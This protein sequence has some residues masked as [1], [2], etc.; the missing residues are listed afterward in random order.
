MPTNQVFDFSI[1]MATLFNFGFTTTRCT[2]ETGDSIHNESSNSD[3][4][5]EDEV[6]ENPFDPQPAINQWSSIVQ[7]R[8]GSRN[9]HRGQEKDQLRDSVSDSDSFDFESQYSNS[10]NESELTEDKL[11]IK[12]FLMKNNEQYAQ[13]NNVHASW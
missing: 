12:T 1:V 13:Y 3:F 8:P 2:I 6:P 11:E 9:D 10:E 5:F 4:D 7:R